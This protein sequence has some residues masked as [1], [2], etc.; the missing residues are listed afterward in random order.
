MRGYHP[1][2]VQDAEH[3]ADYKTKKY[4][5]T[6]A[7]ASASSAAGSRE[8]ERGNAFSKHQFRYPERS[9]APAIWAIS[10]SKASSENE[11]SGTKVRNLSNYVSSHADVATRAA[12]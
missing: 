9:V 4:I 11:T 6:A 8:F 1:T 2:P 5:K 3:D 12:S 7:A 10:E